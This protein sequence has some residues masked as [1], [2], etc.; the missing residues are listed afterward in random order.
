MGQGRT[1]PTTSNHFKILVVDDDDVMLLLLKRKLEEFD[2][3]FQVETVNSATT[4]LELCLNGNYG[5]VVTDLLMPKMTGLEFWEELKVRMSPLEPPSFIVM[6]GVGSEVLAV[7]ALQKGIT[8]YITKRSNL[9]SFIIE[10][11][12][13]LKHIATLNIKIEEQRFLLQQRQQQLDSVMFQ[14]NERMKE[15]DFVYKTTQLSTPDLESFVSTVLSLVPPAFKQPSHTT[16][17]VQLDGREYY[18]N[19]FKTSEWVLERTIRSKGD[20]VGW[21]KVYYFGNDLMEGSPF[22]R[23]EE[24]LIEDLAHRLG[25]LHEQVTIDHKV[26]FQA[27]LLDSVRESIVATDLDGKL[28][29]WGK[30]AE[31]LYGYSEEEVLGEPILLIL[32]SEEKEAELE[33]MKVVREEG[34]WAGQYRQTRK[35]GSLFWSETQIALI[36]DQEGKPMG[37]VGIDRDI[38]VERELKKRLEAQKEELSEFAH[39]MAHDLRNGLSKIEGYVAM[40][41]QCPNIDLNLQKS[42]RKQIVGVREILDHSLELAEAGEVVEEQ[43]EVELDKLLGEVAEVTLPPDTKL[44]ILTPKAA[45]KGGRTK[46]YQLF[47]NILENAVVHGQASTIQVSLSNEQ[48]R[49][50]LSILNNGNLIDP[51]VAQLINDGQSDGLGMRIVQKISQAHGWALEVQPI[52]GWT[53]V[54][55]LIS[56]QKG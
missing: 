37:M 51:L 47:K 41:D 28:V 49:S 34:F 23:E 6:T 26:R 55:F 16:A 52:E 29:Y 27:A 18:S 8:H 3:S 24:L 14:L 22:L 1:E 48:G 32:P 20:S 5:V 25:H 15:L 30:G 50:Y 39:V 42:I 46:L 21:I 17:M 33:R 19:R 31:A 4:A 44:E 11:G 38:T 43:E 56:K 53:K 45:L 36:R 40:L 7:E 13:V 54:S 35:D 2:N 9:Q 12:S 10:L